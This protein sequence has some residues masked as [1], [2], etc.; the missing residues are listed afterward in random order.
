M[1]NFKISIFLLL[2]LAATLQAAFVAV[3]ETTADPTVKDMVPLTDRQYLTNVLREQAVKE[4]PAS[5]N[6]TIMTRDNIAAML[7]PGKSIEDC[8]GSCL[9]ETGKN[10]AADYICQ[11]RISSFNGTLTLSAELYETAGNKLIASFNGLGSNIS[12]LLTLIIN[13]SPEFFRSVKNNITIKTPTR[14]ESTQASKTQAVN[15]QNEPVNQNYFD[16]TPQ[17]SNE[18]LPTPANKKPYW[19]R[20]GFFFHAGFLDAGLGL[21]LRFSHQNGVYMTADARWLSSLEDH[22]YLYIPTLFYFGG[23]VVHF[24]TGPTFIGNS[25]NGHNGVLLALGI[26]WDIGRHVGIDALSFIPSKEYMEVTIVLDFRVV[27]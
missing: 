26:N 1:K 16:Q 7:P 20:V 18:Y 13:K 14:Q 21:K 9:A 11:A 24:V 23:N 19:P 15:A 6:Y 22:N 12:Q 8:E 2:A 27:F 4:L 10:I 17:T 25:D 3:L 5:Q